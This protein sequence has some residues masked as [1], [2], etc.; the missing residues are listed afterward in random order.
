[1]LKDGWHAVETPP[2][3]EHV[4]WSWTSKT[5][6]SVAFKNPKKDSLFYFDLD[7][8]SHAFP[9]GQR[10]QV[11]LGDQIVDDFILQPAHQ[12]LRTIR[13]PAGKMGSE[14]MVELKIDVDK[15]FVPAQ[16]TPGSKDGRELGVRVF[17]A[18]VAPE[19]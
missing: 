9:D 3:N 15:T 11:R 6:A 4:E 16:A 10:V 19:K 13:L 1:M 14:D 8:P 18:V 2:N 7:N 12:L 5:K 17:H